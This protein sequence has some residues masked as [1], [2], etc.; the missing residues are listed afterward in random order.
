[1]RATAPA[2]ATLKPID[3]PFRRSDHG[4]TVGGVDR[5]KNERKNH[6]AHARRNVR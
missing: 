6:A 4:M 3:E 1:M 5:N 2:M